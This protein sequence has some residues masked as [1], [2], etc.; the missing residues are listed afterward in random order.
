M[1]DHL[2]FAEV[3]EGD[4]HLADFIEGEFVVW[5]QSQLRGEVE[6]HAEP[7]LAGLQEVSVPSVGVLGRPEASVLPY[8]PLAAPIHCRVHSPSERVAARESQRGLVAPPLLLQ[9]RG[10]AQPL[11]G[12][13]VLRK[14]LGRPFRRGCQVG[15]Q[16]LRLPL[17]QTDEVAPVGLPP[18]PG[19][20]CPFHRFSHHTS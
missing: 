2:H 17:G 4:P 7:R 19:T 3:G 20:F 5:V 13:A 11:Y 12:D 1:E 10:G 6:G 15:R 16:D 8:R 18:T 14:E 9:L